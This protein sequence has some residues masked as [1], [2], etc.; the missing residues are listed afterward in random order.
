[1]RRLMFLALLCAF[2]L[3]SQQKKVVV[4]IQDPDLMEKLRTA[5]P[6]A[7][8]VPVSSDSVMAEI[9][10]ADA[11]IGD[12]TSPQVRAGKNLKWVGVMSAGVERV[13]FPKDGT[14]DLRMSNIVLTNNKI[15]Q[16]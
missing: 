14:N 3:H 11:F 15:V 8:I 1:M 10:D 4:D 5:A 16:G 9:A 2:E 7:R 6:Q 13:L 12:I